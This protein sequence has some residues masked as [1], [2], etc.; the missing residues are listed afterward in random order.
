MKKYILFLICLAFISCSQKESE[1]KKLEET[2]VAADSVLKKPKDFKSAHQR[3]KEDY[4]KD[5][6]TDSIPERV[7]F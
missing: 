2:E 3:D 5:T 7:K 4:G 1:H 6:T